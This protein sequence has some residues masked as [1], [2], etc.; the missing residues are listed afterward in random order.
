MAK[1][2][3][4]SK[5]GATLNVSFTPSAKMQDAQITKAVGRQST[6][7]GFAFYNGKRDI[8]FV[9]KQPDALRRA[10]QRLRKAYGYKVSLQIS[11]Y[12]D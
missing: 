6:G 7:S 1:I 5:R 11:E 10:V 9:F 2:T 3:F 8:D 12:D 4:A